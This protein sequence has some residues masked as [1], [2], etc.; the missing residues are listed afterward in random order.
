MSYP[1]ALLGGLIVTGFLSASAPHAPAQDAVSFKDKRIKLVVGSSP[2]GG[3]DNSGRLV[4]RYMGKFLPGNPSV[5]VQNMPGAGGTIALGYL[6]HRA[7]PDGLTFTI[8]SQ[9]TMDPL[10]FRRPNIR[11]KPQD[12]PL[13]GSVNR[14]GNIMFVHP[15]AKDRLYDKSAKPVIIGNVGALP[16]A[17]VMPAIW[18][19]EYLGWNAKWVMGYPGT[20]ELMLAYDRGEVDLA[21]TSTMR[22]LK[23]KLA[24]NELVILNQSGMYTHGKV[25]GR[26]EFG[27]VPV[28][29][30]QMRN[31]KMPDLARKALEYWLAQRELDKWFALVPGTPANIVLLYRGAFDKMF[32]DE[33]FLT[34]GVAMSEGFVAIGWKDTEVLVR[35][36][37]GTSPETLDFLKNLMAK[38]GMKSVKAKPI[39][40]VSTVLSEVQR[41]GRVLVF[42]VK[43]QA[44]KTRVSGS[45][46][47]VTIAG[48]TSRRGQLK[49]GMSC[50]IAYSGNGSQAKSVD[51]K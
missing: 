21:A 36:L 33:E 12:F 26:P 38:Q 37:T 9:V 10:I 3:T 5:F 11:Y 23:E 41:D 45:R 39:Q 20:G 24:K 28:F 1:R 34:S 48:K 2:G 22:L 49:P 29:Y 4:A 18:G 44:S 51:C 30:N 17:G 6:T 40:K 32:A 46:T 14:G 8:S 50:V 25:V 19:I 35:N 7:K 13:I 16:R 31:V 27:D 43:G 42:D 15:R 47:A